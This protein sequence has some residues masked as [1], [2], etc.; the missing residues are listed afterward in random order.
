MSFAMSILAVGNPVEEILDMPWRI[1][2][3]PAPWLSSQI[4]VMLL[5]SAILLAA[6]PLLTRR[7]LPRAAKGSMGLVELI[8][9][10]IRAQIAQPALGKR[11]DKGVPYLATLFSFLLLCNLLS[12]VPLA[13]LSAAIRLNGW[14]GVDAK[15]EPLNVT[16]IG[17]T[18]A[19]GLWVCA[20]FASL[21]FVLVIF[22]G[23]FVRLK[24]LWKGD[25]YAKPDDDAMD[26]SKAPAPGIH[27]PPEPPSTGGDAHRH[28]EGHRHEGNVGH[29]PVPAGAN[30]WM[31]AAQWL[32]MRRWPL[33]AAAPL[34][35]W[36]W[37]NSFVPPVP[38]V[39]GL[40]MWPVLLVLE[41]VGYVAKCFALCIRL[42]ANMT[43]GHVMLAVLVMFAVEARGWMIPMVSLSA[44][45]GVVALMFLELLVAV[46]QAYIFTFLSA[47]FIGLATSEQH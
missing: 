6:I 28:P 26:P 9:A 18:P 40:I 5:A 21:T 14:G 22:S 11:A 34:A 37:L 4:A 2:G 23:Y 46:I 31:G 7:G 47:L 35:I 36:P 10:F 24:K 32:E 17:G 42:L 20:A 8:V 44:G 1:G 3:R 16:P 27:A 29:G 38:G 39:P 19:S 15:G 25:P 41:F 45:A 43:G 33:A 13:P 30:I 12:L